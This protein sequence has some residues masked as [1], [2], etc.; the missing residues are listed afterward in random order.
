MDKDKSHHVGLQETPME[1][2]KQSTLPNFN[3][4]AQNILKLYHFC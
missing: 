4:L 3:I 1:N 2:I